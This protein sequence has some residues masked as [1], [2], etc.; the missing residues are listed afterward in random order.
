MINVLHGLG[1]RMLSLGVT[2]PFLHIGLAHNYAEVSD[3]V[4]VLHRIGESMKKYKLPKVIAPLTFSFTGSGNVSQVRLGSVTELLQI[5]LS[6][7]KRTFC[8]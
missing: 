5:L 3:V 6:S 4:P 8:F 2:S 7:E 1:L